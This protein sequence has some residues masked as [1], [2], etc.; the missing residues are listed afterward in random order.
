M[1]LFGFSVHDL[2]WVEGMLESLKSMMISGGKLNI[3]GNGRFKP[4]W[5]VC[6]HFNLFVNSRSKFVGGIKIWYNIS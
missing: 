3:D 4:F 6:R 1:F 5:A 2:F